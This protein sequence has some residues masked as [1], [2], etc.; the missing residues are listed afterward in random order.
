ML[1]VV[2]RHVIK[3]ATLRGDFTGSVA[4]YKFKRQQSMAWAEAEYRRVALL[5]TELIGSDGKEE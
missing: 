1:T 5:L 4:V 2:K 3:H